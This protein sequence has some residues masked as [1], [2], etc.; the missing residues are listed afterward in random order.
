[1][2]PLQNNKTSG[3]IYALCNVQIFG[4]TSFLE[5]FLPKLEGLAFSLCCYRL[6]CWSDRT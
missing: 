3:K 1:M 2:L 4:R 5:R 6:V